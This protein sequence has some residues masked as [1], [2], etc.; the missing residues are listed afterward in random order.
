MNMKKKYAKFLIVLVLFSS[1]ATFAQDYITAIQ[2]H[3]ET[4]RSILNISQEDILDLKIS[5]Q[6]TNKRNN[7]THVYAIQKVNGINIRNA[8]VSAAFKNGEIISLAN[9]FEKNVLLRATTFVPTL[10]PVQA[11]SS[12]A[13]TLGLGTATFSVETAISSHEFL[14]STGGVSLEKVPTQLVYETVGDVLKLAWDLNIHTTN[15]KHWWSVRV[16][17]FT[18]E[19]INQN[20]WIVSCSFE[21]HNHKA[22]L[23]NTLTPRKASTFS[24]DK[25]EDNI[26][27]LA[28]ERYNVFPLPIESPNHGDSSIVTDPQNAT[29]SPFGWHDTDGIAGA[30]F[31]I[32]RG[33]NVWAQDDTNGNNGTGSSPDGGDA[34]DFDF[35]FN[36]NAEPITMLDASTTNLFYWNNILHDILYQYGFDEASGNFQERN[37]TD[38]GSGSDSVNADAQDGQ[39]LNNANFATPPDGTN[40]RMQ[41]F[42]WSATG[43]SETVTIN[44]GSLDGNYIGVRAQFGDAFPDNGLT[45]DLVLINDNSGEATDGCDT[46]T[47]S[48]DLNG[49]IVVIRRGICEF[50]F[51]VLTAENEGAVAVIVVNNEG[52]NPIA[53]APGDDGGDVTIPSLMMTQEDGNAL[54]EAIQDGETINATLING[55]TF[56]LDGS[57]DNGVVAHEYGH[58]VSNRLTGGRFNSNCMTTCLGFDADGCIPGQGTEVMS[59]GW[60]DFLTLILTLEPGDQPEDARGI[61][62]YVT[63][64]TTDGVGIRPTQYST[65][66]A[67][68]GSDYSDLPDFAQ[69]RAPHGVGYLWNTML[70][71]MTWALIDQYGFDADIYNGTGG[72]NIALQL[73]IDGL[74]LQPC[75]PGFV[76]GRDAILAAVDI[77]ELITEADRDAVKCSIWGVFADRGLGLSAD[78]GNWQSRSDGVAAFDIPEELGSVCNPILST[79]DRST[80][81][82]SVFPNPSNGGISINVGTNVGEGT[83]KVFDINGREVFSSTETL[84][85]IVRIQA[86]GLATGIYLLQ[87]QNETVFQ[88]TNIII[89]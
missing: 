64:Q 69:S 12:A 44:G 73:V 63:G 2:S 77:N 55:D 86:T 85:G 39:R 81:N 26:V 14:L 76:D 75:N 22:P 6:V 31:T 68:N 51:K 35:P 49:K 5:D 24:F 78:Q 28:G 41:M 88:T 7:V 80:V 9:R 20:D 37:Y 83:I 38:E 25:K 47:N 54:I 18:G 19:I 82:F 74:K 32:T 62:T 70:W 72:N 4:N 45:E 52:G 15:G 57:L 40:P 53:M 87:I 8:T 30:E 59:E 46:L 48:A 29:A 79:S 84:E 17:A 67:I 3:F 27:T 61:G 36:F 21:S 43:V 58:G 50:G 89:N 13:S 71:D 33:N 11:A 56:Q 42:L 34:L 16:D 66:T 60:S 10:N 23:E 1:S 65:D